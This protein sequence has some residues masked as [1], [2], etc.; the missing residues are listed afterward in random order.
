MDLI[1]IKD[2]RGEM[3]TSND[4]TLDMIDLVF[5]ASFVLIE[6]FSNA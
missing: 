3:S 5:S 1:K 6:S 2:R 4:F